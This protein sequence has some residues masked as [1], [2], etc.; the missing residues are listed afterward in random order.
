M[1][2]VRKSFEISAAHMLSLSYES[3]CSNL[4]GHNWNI[5]VACR[6]EKL[7]KDGMVYDFKHIKDLISDTLDHQ[8]IT[9]LIVIDGIHLNPTAENIAHWVS[10]KI[11]ETCFEVVVKESDGN[12]AIWRK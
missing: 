10:K 5:T 4:H 2:E 6:S 7:N 9:N 11:G 12:T 8:N 1:Y 3:K